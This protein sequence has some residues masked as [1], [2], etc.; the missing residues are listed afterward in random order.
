MRF[1]RRPWVAEDLNTDERYVEE[2]PQERPVEKGDLLEG[3]DAR[4][5]ALE[6]GNFLSGVDEEVR[7]GVSVTV[8][9][10]KPDPLV[11]KE[12]GVL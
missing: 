9:V 4:E 2:A 6:D 8:T 5:L 7:L 1:V 11:L 3:A 10:L 12:D